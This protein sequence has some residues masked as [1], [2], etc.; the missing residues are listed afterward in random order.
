MSNLKDRQELLG[1]LNE[2]NQRITSKRKMQRKLLWFELF[3]TLLGYSFLWYNT[4]G[5]VVFG[6]FLIHF[7]NNLGISR[8]VN[9]KENNSAKQIWREE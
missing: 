5:W 4:N 1:E 9:G 8:T 7:G 2:I 6:I 3:I